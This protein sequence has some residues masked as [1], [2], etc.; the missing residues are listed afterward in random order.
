MSFWS[1]GTLRMCSETG[2]TMRSGGEPCALPG[3]FG[4]AFLAAI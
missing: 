2:E 3:R 4:I 1:E